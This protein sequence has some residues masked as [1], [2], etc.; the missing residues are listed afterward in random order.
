MGPETAKP[1]GTPEL[2]PHS[3]TLILL[4]A[5]ALDKLSPGF[6]RLGQKIL[7]GTAYQGHCLQLPNFPGGHRGW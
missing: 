3:K 2:T 5:S 4:L 1:L 6:L 7:E